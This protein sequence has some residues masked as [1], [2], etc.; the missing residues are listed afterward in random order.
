LNDFDEDRN[1]KKCGGHRPWLQTAA[2]T[3]AR[4]GTNALIAM[5]T[6][7]PR[8]LTVAAKVAMENE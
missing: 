2:R 3:P 7:A 4:N 5:L 8:I 1:L 6:C